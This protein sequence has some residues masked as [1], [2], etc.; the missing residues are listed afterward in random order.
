MAQ[1]VASWAATTPA[2][3]LRPPRVRHHELT[4]GALLDDVSIRDAEVLAIT[5][6]AGF[7]KSTLA[8]QWASRSGSPVASTVPCPQR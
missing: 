2:S 7:G 5:A 8:I 6:P 4:R 3:K 1:R